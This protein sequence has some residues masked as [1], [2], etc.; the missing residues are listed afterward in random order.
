MTSVL[1]EPT[2]DLTK[3][4]EVSDASRVLTRAADVIEEFGWCQGV[5]CDS[6]T[7]SSDVWDSSIVGF[8]A[9]GAIWRAEADLGLISNLWPTTA[10][11]SKGFLGKIWELAGFDSASG[12]DYGRVVGFNDHPDTEKASVVSM[13]RRLAEE[14]A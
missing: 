2:T 7:P 4:D 14:R 5:M 8:C 10:L 9:I 12:A 11:E 1:V 13:L 6:P 3:P